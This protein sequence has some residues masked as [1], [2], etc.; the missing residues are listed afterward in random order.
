M[1][2]SRNDSGE[3]I[4]HTPA[5]EARAYAMAL[6]GTIAAMEGPGP[7]LAPAVV[8]GPKTALQTYHEAWRND[9]LLDGLVGNSGPQSG[10]G[11]INPM[12]GHGVY[13][14]DKVMYGRFIEAPRLDDTQLTALFNNNDIA[15][16]IATARPNE[17]F[18]RG[19]CL[20][21]PQDL[22]QE[23]VKDAG[24]E[25]TEQPASGE[26]GPA[27]P[28]SP[29][30]DPLG[31]SPDNASGN[32]PLKGLNA[33]NPE[34][35]GKRQPIAGGADP[36]NATANKP[37]SSIA[38]SAPDPYGEGLAKGVTTPTRPNS[39]RKVAPAAD[40][41]TQD[42]GAD[43]AKAAE[44]YAG[45]LG[46]VARAYEASVFAGVYGGGILIIGADDGQDMSTPL[47][48]KNIKTIRYLS[49]VDRRFVFASTWY[50]DIGPKYGEVETWEIINP[51]GGSANTRIHETRVVRFDGAPVDF[52]MRRRLLGW[53]LSRYQAPYDTMRQFDMSFQ[54]VSNLMSD[55]A[56]ACM[57]INGLAQ[58]ISSDPQTLQTRMR[59]VDQSRS[60]GT[61]LYIDAENE[62]FER[63]TTPLTG[64]ADVIHMLMLRLAA[65]VNMP[66]ALL[67]GREPSGLNATGDA[68]FRRFY[69]VVSGE[70]KSDLEP[71]LRRVYTLILLAKDGPTKGRLP[72]AGVQF[73]WPKLY[74]PS[75]VEQ[76]TIRW[77][78][79][80]SDAA[81]V[82]NKILL[83]EEVAKS[84]FRNGELHLDTEIDTGLRAEKLQEAELPPNA[85]DEAKTQQENA[86]KD[87]QAAVDQAG[88]AHELAKAALNAKT[89]T[90]TPG[91][92]PGASSGVNRPNTPVRKDSVDTA[93]VDAEWDNIR[94]DAEA[95]T[96]HKVM[97]E[98][99]PPE[100][101]SWV[102]AGQWKQTN[103][104]RT[105]IDYSGRAG[106]QAS[107]AS[108]RER[109]ER[110]VPEIRDGSI[111][112]IILVQP[113]KG[114]AIIVDGHHRALAHMYEGSEKVPAYICPVQESDGP[115][116]ATH[117]AQR[118]RTS[119]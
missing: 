56:Q 17:M 67:F 65:A 23:G 21:I 96:V 55:L 97:S 105:D 118:N 61:M 11:W 71:R 2:V 9:N 46:L 114:K 41:V 51:F 103:V 115:W 100:A 14:R 53:T 116:D 47:N 4:G 38:A 63:K 76:S 16:R 39:N 119:G 37:A 93:E 90:F 66:V 30:V 50:A 26:S 7:L 35:L 3:A 25:P 81:Y 57:S 60:S 52:L 85:A 40:K 6:C 92:K 104:R 42:S 28:G 15:H 5:E 83:P 113:P 88:Q 89:Q 48:E 10:G 75:E 98:D 22:D 12:T 108:D 33:A 102:L 110:F 43:I 70:I 44:V 112:P 29:L 74:E 49:W 107:K 79:A 54:S 72:S 32:G 82:A 31:A 24:R 91:G 109:V 8:E 19:W 84:R 77:N 20:V 86:D 58:M 27:A 99:F 18:R 78:M 36:K 101:I 34:Q 80:Q 106:W 62:K 64:V 69:D 87:R 117:D 94:C 68:D 59:L 73:V 45:R 95:A 111:K 1:D 13:G